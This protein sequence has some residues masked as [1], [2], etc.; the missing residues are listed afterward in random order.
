MSNSDKPRIVVVCPGRGSYGPDELG[1][2][3]A[4]ADLI[5][6]LLEHIERDRIR[7]DRPPLLDLDR[8]PQFR[9]SQH[10]PGEH[11]AAMI[12]A[13]AM[14]DWVRLASYHVDIVAV[15][16]NS[17][18]WYLAL[19]AAQALTFEAGY[20][21]VDTMGSMMRE[22]I[23]GGQLIYP[24]VDS[25]WQI[26]IE[27]QEHLLAT[28]NAYNVDKDE[29]DKIYE[30]IR[31][32]GYAILAGSE[33]ALSAMQNRLQAV[34]P[35][36]PTRI[37]H[38]AAFHSPLLASTSEHAFHQLP[39]ALFHIPTRPL[40]D[41]R[42]AMYWPHRTNIDELRNYTLGAQVTQMYDFSLS[43]RVALRE[44]APDYIVLLGPGDQLGGAI[45]QILVQQRWLDI[46]NKSQ[47]KARQED[48]PF[49]LCMARDDDRT[50]LG[51]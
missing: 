35:R 42:G 36:F 11:A 9:A 26:D 19:A 50:R 4:R 12:Y 13:C 34:E 15:L 17:M 46:T 29:G 2:L 20:Q 27:R 28:M 38:H 5:S 23:I 18:G 24:I 37:P 47:F 39:P 22:R 43:L 10:L 44:F 21:L 30:S 7:S 32:G 33:D 3:S 8:R 6:D 31:L 25:N 51:Q 40:I 41:G 1:Y 45:G 49:V 48:Q 14:A 16:G